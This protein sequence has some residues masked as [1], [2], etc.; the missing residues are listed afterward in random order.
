MASELLNHV[1][2]YI[3]FTDDDARRVG[4][5]A[6]FVIPHR[7]GIV[8]AFY[9]VVLAH[10]PTARILADPA[11]IE[12]LRA[13]LANWLETLFCGR[14]DEAYAA[15]R[16][17][18]GAAHVRVG[19]PQEYMLAGMEVIRVEVE[20][21]V[22]AARPP[23]EAARVDS[24]RKLLTIELALM[25]DAYKTSY[26]ERVREL[27]RAKFQEQML[28]V[29]Q[30]AQLGQMAASL[31]HEVKNPLAGISGAIQVIRDG[32]PAADPHRP[33]LIEILRQI[34]RLDG[35]VKDLLNYARPRPPRIAACSV[36]ELVSRV[37]SFLRQEPAFQKVP[38][39]IQ[40]KPGSGTLFA[41]GHQLE[42]LLLNLLL[43][44]AHASPP[45]SPVRLTVAPDSQWVT[46]AVEDRGHGMDAQT[47]AQAFKAFFTTKARGT[48]LGL[49]IS[50]QI[51]EAHGGSIDL[52]SSP[53]AGTRVTV[54]LP[55]KLRATKG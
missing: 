4:A 54:R 9:K 53:G 14:Y 18:I 2:S 10:E 31:A 55:R 27:E 22:A 42:Q 39:E 33:I 51:V 3:G 32:L 21:V 47:R 50:R 16:A 23:E 5:L 41:D 49:P 40:V 26:S 17:G 24:L 30:L 15:R 45:G 44:A 11:R 37:R 7:H 20:K 25:L 48:G 36:E 29:E 1:A 8:D 12:S 35:T 43:N 52:E 34:D 46:V 38:L 13:H 19:L 28:R 6:A